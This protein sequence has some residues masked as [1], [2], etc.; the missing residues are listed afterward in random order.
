MKIKKFNESKEINSSDKYEY[1]RVFEDFK[2]KLYEIDPQDD[3]ETFNYDETDLK[4]VVNYLLETKEDM[5]DSKLLIIKNIHTTSDITDSKE[6][7]DMIN[8]I[9]LEKDA[10]KYNL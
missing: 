7:K 3:E 8:K 5:P 1:Y 9:K 4:D 2:D 6:V 10:E